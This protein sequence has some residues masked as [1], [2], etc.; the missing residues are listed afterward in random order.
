MQRNGFSGQRTSTGNDRGTQR[1][2]GFFSGQ[3]TST[4]NYD[5]MNMGRVYGRNRFAPRQ[6]TCQPL[7]DGL[8]E[9][10]GDS[11]I[12]RSLKNFWD[13]KESGL[14]EPSRDSAEVHRRFSPAEKQNLQVTKEVLGDAKQTASV[15]AMQVEQNTTTVQEV[16][17]HTT[18][19]MVA[20]QPT[21][22]QESPVISRELQQ[23]REEVRLLRGVE[24][25]LAE[26]T[27]EAKRLKH[28]KNTLEKDFR[29]LQVRTGELEVG[30]S[31]AAKDVE[32]LK[33]ENTDLQASQTR[34]RDMNEK[35]AEKVER[36]EQLFAV[37]KP[38]HMPS[39]GQLRCNVRDIFE[40]SYD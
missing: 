24:K 21:A 27:E 33:E 14:P 23:L 20:K 5:E 39:Y 4:G 30:L 29:A 18:T 9:E 17:E 28:E 26:R 16:T 25:D 35:N 7:D 8:E 22:A 2:E 3:R 1:F 6:F 37:K 34:L 31:D 13:V 15:Q 40:F 36:L 12:E 38:S 10:Q 32:K 11:M 19:V